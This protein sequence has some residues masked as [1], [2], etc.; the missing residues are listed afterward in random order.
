MSATDRSHY[1][2]SRQGAG[3]AAAADPFRQLRDSESEAPASSGVTPT[4]PSGRSAQHSERSQREDG[5][6]DLPEYDQSS[7][8]WK[9]SQLKVKVTDRRA[10]SSYTIYLSLAAHF[11]VLLW[12]L[13]L[14]SY[15]DPGLTC[16]KP[17]R[18]LVV[19]LAIL[20]GIS[21]LSILLT[22][23]HITVILRR[24]VTPAKSVLREEA[25]DEEAAQ[26]ERIGLTHSQQEMVVSRSMTDRMMYGCCSTCTL[27]LSTLVLLSLLIALFVYTVLGTNTCHEKMPSFTRNAAFLCLGILGILIVHI[28]T[29]S[30]F[31]Y[32]FILCYEIHFCE[33]SL[34]KE[35]VKIRT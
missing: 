2:R 18:G 34:I 27:L 20:V 16:S 5:D 1:S 29:Y 15:V 8:E 25:D 6:R 24:F 13:W 35:E 9:Y 30:R 26:A 19:A 12:C 31:T 22:H 23:W 28:V 21:L 11:V 32:D 14:A 10:Q 17:L 3:A 7:V 4:G 33:Q